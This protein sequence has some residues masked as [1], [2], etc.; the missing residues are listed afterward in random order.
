MEDVKIIKKRRLR[1]CRFFI[2]I[3]VRRSR[4]VIQSKVSHNF[5]NLTLFLRILISQPDMSSIVVFPH[6]SIWFVSIQIT[7]RIQLFLVFKKRCLAFNL[8]SPEL[9]CSLFSLRQI[10]KRCEFFFLFFFFFLTCYESSQVVKY[11]QLQNVFQGN[12]AYNLR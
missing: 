2:V 9:T 11:C 8:Y 3:R 1:S 6:Y 10:L 4:K 7:F 12:A 5:S